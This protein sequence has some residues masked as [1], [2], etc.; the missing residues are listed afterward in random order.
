MKEVIVDSVFGKIEKNKWDYSKKDKI[1]I[2][3]KEVLVNLK[4]YCEDVDEGINDAQR[5]S[6]KQLKEEVDF[7]KIEKGIYEYYLSVYE[8]YRLMDS[9]NKDEIAPIINSVDEVSK[10]VNLTS[11]FISEDED[12]P[13]VNLMF[14]CTWD[15]ESGVGVKLI[16]GEIEAIADQSTA[17]YG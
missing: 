10:L 13:S 16:N 15:I 7:S 3:K 5:E 4:V 14:T 17:I 12:V 8:E 2:F 6:Y 11:I 1:K 9:E